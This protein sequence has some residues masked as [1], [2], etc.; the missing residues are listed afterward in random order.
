MTLRKYEKIWRELKDK[1]S[2]GWIV[3]NLSGENMQTIINMVQFEKSQATVAR[4]G[5]DMPKFGKLVI[6]REPEK[7]RVL[8][9]LKDSGDA[10]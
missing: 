9:R 7:K 2:D 4:R 1:G 3:V 6:R 8:F 10:L 5:L